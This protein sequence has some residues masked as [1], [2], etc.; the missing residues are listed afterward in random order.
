MALL[1]VQRGHCYRTS[2]ATGTRGEQQYAT[3][4]ADR[5]KA[6]VNEVGHTVRIINADV[7]D[8]AYRGDAFVALHWDG[9]TSPDAHGASVGYQ[10][11]E[12]RR[13]ASFWKRH[14]V[15]NG[16]TRGFRG[17]NYTAALGGYYGVREARQNGNRCAFIS[18]AGFQSNAGDMALMAGTKGP[19][20]VALAV[21]AAMV[22]IFGGKCPPAPPPANLPAY[23]G[24]VEKG[25]TG[26]AVRAWQTQLSAL[27][28][29]NLKVDGIFGDETEAHVFWFQ[30][31]RGIR[32]DGI[33]GPE[34]WHHLMDARGFI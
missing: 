1:V 26:A 4:A 23:P 3:A 29:Y 8:A 5:V 9:S 33:C 17:D 11:D 16:W 13:F 22:D 18:E 10:T 12:G 2:G 15:A 20:R 30:A 7:A 6:R 27:P 14:Y 19:D 21:A 25:D 31:S 24:L 34:T 28:D 32:V